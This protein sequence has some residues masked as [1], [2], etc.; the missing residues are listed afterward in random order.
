MI[1]CIFPFAQPSFKQTVI[2]CTNTVCQTS[3]ITNGYL[4]IPTFGSRSL[5]TFEW[6]QTAQCYIKVGQGY[7]NRRITHCLSDIGRPG[8]RQTDI[9]KTT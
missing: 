8:K 2:L 3:G 5:L 6:K 9:G 4:F 1:H 7:R